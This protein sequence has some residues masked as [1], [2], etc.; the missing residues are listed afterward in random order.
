[1]RSDA[2]ERKRGRPEGTHS[3]T[4]ARAL[5]I[6]AALR[7]GHHIKTACALAGVGTST[8][9]RWLHRAELAEYANA[10][11][12]PHDPADDVYCNFRDSVMRARAEAAET[13]ID[14]VIRAAMGGQLVSEGPALD[15]AGNPIRDTGGRVLLR[16]KWTQPDG[17][18]ALSYLKVAQPEEFSVGSSSEQSLA[19][20]GNMPPSAHP[21][22]GQIGR[23]AALLTARVADARRSS[24][25]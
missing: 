20:G 11:G 12:R 24:C 5:R 9:Y 7:A 23:L 21:D 3:L 14:V 19:T 1:M 10:C 6:E 13:M 15:G 16:R 4:P 8:F 2:G 18:L 17:R 25:Y 22:D